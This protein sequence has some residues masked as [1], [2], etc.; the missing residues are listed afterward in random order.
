MPRR[1]RLE[2]LLTDDQIETRYRPASLASRPAIR[3]QNGLNIISQRMRARPP[4]PIAVMSQ[5]LT[6]A[7][8]SLPPGSDRGERSIR[9]SAA[10]F[11]S[12]D[13]LSVDLERH[14]S[15]ALAAVWQQLPPAFPQDPH[16]GSRIVHDRRYT[17]EVSFYPP[18]TLQSVF[19]A[20][21]QHVSLTHR[22][23]AP[24]SSDS[25][26]PRRAHALMARQTTTV[27]CDGVSARIPSRTAAVHGR[28]RPARSRMTG[29]H[30]V[31][32]G[33]RRYSKRNAS[34][35]AFT[36]SDSCSFNQCPAVGKRRIRGS[37][38][39]RSSPSSAPTP[40]YGSSSPHNTSVGAVTTRMGLSACQSWRSCR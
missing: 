32:G 29:C 1:I 16:S 4:P 33:A 24:L 15:P 25:A 39:Q 13:A 14:G 6:A 12:Q 37:R 7:C 3:D 27:W 35:S 17:V 9:V 34:S 30:L 22:R 11:T 2:P 40:M 10:S 26:L 21:G 23:T 36:R 8:F 20:A 38:T 28:E 19:P 31:R 18:T 5:G